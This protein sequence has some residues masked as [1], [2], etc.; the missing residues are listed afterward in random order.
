MIKRFRR[1]F[2]ENRGLCLPLS[3]DVRGRRASLRQVLRRADRT[4]RF[5]GAAR[6]FSGRC[7]GITSFLQRYTGRLLLSVCSF[8]LYFII[9]RAES[10]EE[11]T[12]FSRKDE[13]VCL[14][15]ENG[16][17]QNLIDSQTPCTIDKLTSFLIL[18][19]HIK[20][21]FT[22]AHREWLCVMILYRQT[23]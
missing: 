10:K 20:E 14:F 18:K 1:G 19:E 3:A 21:P 11:C 13:R 4:D 17:L 2:S 23:T 9:S 6:R 5:C 8:F 12:I 7:H 15:S 22:G 16:R